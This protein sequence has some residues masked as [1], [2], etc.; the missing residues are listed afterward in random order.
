M[1]AN[2]FYRT[3][4]HLAPMSHFIEDEIVA[5]ASE[6]GSS[7]A[8]ASSADLK[9]KMKK[10]LEKLIDKAKNYTAKTLTEDTDEFDNMTPEQTCD[11]IYSMFIKKVL[12]KRYFEKSE[13]KEVKED[14]KTAVY[15]VVMNWNENKFVEDC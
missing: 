3:L 6:S 5:Y 2:A 7:I 15:E 11:E 1:L 14:V 13:L 9:S 12:K 8:Y 4:R 10:K